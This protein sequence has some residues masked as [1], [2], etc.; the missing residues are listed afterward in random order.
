MFTLR[1]TPSWIKNAV[2]KQPSDSLDPNPFLQILKSSKIA[3]P[4]PGGF[5]QK[6][7]LSDGTQSCWAL[8]QPTVEA[9]FPEKK[10]DH[11]VV[12][13][14]RFSILELPNGRIL[15]VSNMEPIVSLPTPLTYSDAQSLSIDEPP[16]PLS[17][18][19][20]DLGQF[21]E[22]SKF[23]DVVFSLPD[24][25]VTA[26]KVILCARSP[27][28]RALLCNGM[29]E[30]E[31]GILTEIDISYNSEI[32]DV[33]LKWIYSDQF[34]ISS[35]QKLYPT[36]NENLE[37]SKIWELWTASTFFC[38]DPLVKIIENHFVKLF[39][40]DNICPFWNY[41]ST[42]QAE[43]LSQSCRK[44]FYNHLSEIMKTN[45][46]L[47]LSRE[48]VKESFY[49]NDPNQ[50]DANGLSISFSPCVLFYYVMYIVY[51]KIYNN[52]IISILDF[53]LKNFRS[54]SMAHRNEAIKI[55]TDSNQPNKLK[56]KLDDL[57]S[58]QLPKKKFKLL[59]QT[60][61]N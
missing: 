27:Y 19:K 52:E 28:F 30:T 56:R 37:T 14:L 8:L 4:Q 11:W 26:H 35:A 61:E 34:S 15:T 5:L 25:Q 50:R 29:K 23:N 17:S 1:L 40:P 55:W 44:Y 7:L 59:D 48:L 47:S 49:P 10:M 32:F 45:S 24:K 2:A 33:I 16:E 31:E 12:K 53:Y 36:S 13:I 6:I 22:E 21:Y 58:E 57:W 38:L 9:R 54:Q 42:L 39:T 20:K 60:V 43:N 18:L 51:S 41:I 46:Y 3:S